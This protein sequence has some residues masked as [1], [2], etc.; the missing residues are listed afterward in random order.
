AGTQTLRTQIEQGAPADVFASANLDHMKAV[1]KA[2][3][4]ERYE[5]FAYNTLAVI[6]P[7]N[8]PAG[9]HSFE[10]LSSEKDYLL[11]IGDDNVPIG[12]YT[13]KLF[14]KSDD[15]YGRGF[16]NEVMNHV[17]SLA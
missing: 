17:V 1:K 10:D 3:R 5:V 9:I 4:V 14:G 6:V 16:Y 7:K 8:N 2:G 11:V 12:M 15:L 13:R